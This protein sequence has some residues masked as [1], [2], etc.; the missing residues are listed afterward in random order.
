MLSD[1][2]VEVTRLSSENSRLKEELAQCE[3]DKEFVWSLWKR[4]QTA[5]PDVT[6]AVTDVQKHEKAKQEDRDNKVRDQRINS[7]YSYGVLK[8]E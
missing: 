4:L 6:S 1:S 7:H 3:K 8:M 2:S 5:N